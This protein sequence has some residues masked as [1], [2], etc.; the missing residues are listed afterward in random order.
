MCVC[1]CLCV[2]EKEKCAASDEGLREGEI[3]DERQQMKREKRRRYE[4]WRL[5]DEWQSSEIG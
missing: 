5:K 4:G 1:V 2:F 3:D